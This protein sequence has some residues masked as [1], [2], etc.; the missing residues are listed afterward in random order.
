MDYN[1]DN[2]RINLVLVSMYCLNFAIIL[3]ATGVIG[4]TLQKIVDANL[5]HEFLKSLTVMPLTPPFKSLAMAVSAYLL[6]IAVH[7][8]VINHKVSKKMLYLALI[9]EISLCVFVM[10]SMGFASNAIVLL[11]I[12][13]VMHSSKYA[14]VRTPFLLVGIFFFMF[15]NNNVFSQLEMVSLSDYLSIYTSNMKIVLQGIESVLITLNFVI[16]VV[17]MYLL[18]QKEVQNSKQIRAMYDELAALNKQLEEYAGLQEKMGETKERNRLAR[19]I[20]DTLGHTLTGITMGIDA[21]VMLLNVNHEA[22][23]KQLNLLSETARKGLED[24]RRSVE[25]LRPDAL[26]RYTLEGAIHNMVDDFNKI[27][28]INIKLVFNVGNND[29]GADIDEFIYRVVQEGI[30]N[31][32]RYADPQNIAV[33]IVKVEN[34]LI[35][36]IEDDG[37]GCKNIK[38]G[39][40]LHHMKERVEQLHGNIRLNGEN[41]FRINIEIPLRQ[42]EVI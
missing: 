41:G 22:V 28:N 4:I 19:E 27:S 3:Y 24:V 37:K 11:F 25:K 16:F 6:F 10:Y 1:K 15:F 7:F 17:F 21:A 26:E 5:A 40:G 39:F 33:S 9:A 14:E 23:L 36:M 38:T 18:I 20:H 35:L 42:L 32:A 2:E 34:T 8:T 29:L 13:N 30:T 12:A 31:A